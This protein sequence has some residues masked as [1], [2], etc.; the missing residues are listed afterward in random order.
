M[1]PINVPLQ[2]E[3]FQKSYGCSPITE[4]PRHFRI[5]THLTYV[6]KLLRSK[7]PG[8]FHSQR[9]K[10]LNVLRNYIQQESFPRC[11]DVDFVPGRPC[12]IDNE[13]NHCAVGH[14][15][16]MDGRGELA[17]KINNCHRYDL[18]A[19]FQVSQLSELGQWVKTSGFSMEELAMI[20]PTYDHMRPRYNIPSPQPTFPFQTTHTNIICDGC[21]MNPLKG[22][23]YWCTGCPDFDF[24]ANCER[25]NTTHDPSH[26]FVKIKTPD[27]KVKETLVGLL[28]SAGHLKPPP[29]PEWAEYDKLD[30]KSSIVDV[31]KLLVGGDLAALPELLT[32]F[33]TA[34]PPVVTLKVLEGLTED[35][36]KKI[37]LSLVMRRKVVSLIERRKK[38]KS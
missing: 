20:Q 4:I 38:I 5:I 10:H 21:R 11:F 36:V 3:S 14:L 19:D 13:N 29:D 1:I 23:R 27:Q 32:K 24:C 8:A 15:I 34:D 22:D 16:K 35:D 30:E 28:K 31:V 17:Q 12:F 33:T 2:D 18:I 6:E 26:L 9:L 7:T 25:T 37:G